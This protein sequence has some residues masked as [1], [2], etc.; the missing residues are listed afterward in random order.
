M[1]RGALE[2]DV[3]EK[4]WA[5]HIFIFAAGVGLEDRRRE[6]GGGNMGLRRRSSLQCQYSGIIRPCFDTSSCGQLLTSA[7]YMHLRVDHPGF[8]TSER[9]LNNAP[10]IATCVWMSRSTRARLESCRANNSLAD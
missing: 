9:K 4:A 8:Q 10:I 6:N 3:Q 1:L 5:A 2:R 7:L